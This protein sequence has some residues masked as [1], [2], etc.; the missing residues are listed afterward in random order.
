M[1]KFCAKLIFYKMGATSQNID[2]IFKE[3]AEIKATQL[4]FNVLLQENNELKIQLKHICEKQNQLCS[5]IQ[6]L[7]QE[8]QFLKQEKIENNLVIQGIPFN[9]GENLEQ[10]IISI[11]AHFKLAIN[12]TDFSVNR[13]IKAKDP[14]TSILVKFI[15]GIHKENLL[16]ANKNSRLFL[17]QFGLSNDLQKEIYM[18]HHLTSFNTQLITKARLLKS[19][20]KI[21]FAWFQNNNV[22]IRETQQSKITKILSENDL[23]KYEKPNL[24]SAVNNQIPVNSLINT[25]KLPQTGPFTSGI[26]LSGLPD[27]EL[28]SRGKLG[29]T[30]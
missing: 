17:H 20:N 10:L 16:K 9:S 2:L 22:L 11:A 21:K 7:S 12:P 1:S 8:V 5:T 13:F 15:N 23:V 27:R 3:L 29:N 4:S 24:G 26:A 28:R 19:Q 18:R 30:N 25:T 6:K 14:A